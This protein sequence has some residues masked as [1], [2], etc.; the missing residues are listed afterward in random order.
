MERAS[1]QERVAE[2]AAEVA[3]EAERTGQI[4]S[5]DLLWVLVRRSRV[6]A[7]KLRARTWRCTG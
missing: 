1:L 4:D 2:M 6:N 3:R 5:A 7:M